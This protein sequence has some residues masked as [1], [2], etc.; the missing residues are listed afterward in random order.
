VNLL[1]AVGMKSI[2]RGRATNLWQKGLGKLKAI[3][4]GPVSSRFLHVLL[5]TFGS[6]EMILS[7]RPFPSPW[8]YGKWVFRVTYG[9]TII[10]SS[11]Q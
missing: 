11:R 5:G 7:F 10:E 8:A 4:K 3:F 2:F 1:E 6:L 9:C